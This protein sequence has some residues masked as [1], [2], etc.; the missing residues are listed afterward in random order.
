[1]DVDLTS[2][3][4]YSVILDAK[5]RGML[6]TLVPWVGTFESHG[7]ANNA[8]YAPQKHQ[9]SAVWRGETDI[10]EYLYNKD[11]TFKSLRITEGDSKDEIREVEA[12]V[13]DGTIDVLTAT[14]RVMENY[15]NGGKCE[16]AAEVFDGK[17]RFEQRFKHVKDVTLAPSK[18]NIFGGEA[19]ECTVEVTPINGEW[20]KKPRGWL[21][22]QEQG[23][24]KGTMPTVWMGKVT[25]TG[26]AVP[27]KIRVKTDYGTLFMHLAEYNSAEKTLV[28]EKRVT[29]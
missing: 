5:T 4:K 29:E 16:G 18:Y 24:D 6:G 19:A 12:E 3:G 13:T 28:A 26:P 21:S 10:K 9:S 8:N 25:E 1:M 14:L 17:R 11:G 2:P 23:R 15:N 27:V 20:S 22:I 7:W